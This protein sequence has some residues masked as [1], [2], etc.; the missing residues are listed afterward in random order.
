MELKK[1]LKAGPIVGI[2]DISPDIVI[3]FGGARRAREEIREKGECERQ[4]PQLRVGGSIGS[5]VLALGKL[6]LNPAIISRISNDRYGDFIEAELH[7]RNIND[8]YISKQSEPMVQFICVL[9]EAGERTIYVYE[10]PGAVNPKLRDEDL[11]LELI[12]RCA[13][14]HANGF[15]NGAIV[16][17]MEK[18]S[19]AGAVVS[20]D[21]NLRV[22]QH[23]LSAERRA[24]IER[25]IAA[26]DVIFGSGEEE[27]FPLNGIRDMR[28]SAMALANGKRIVVARDRTAPV[29]VTDGEAAFERKVVP[30][31]PINTLNSGDT[32]NAGFIAATALGKPLQTAVDWACACAASVITS[33]E[34]CHVPGR[35][36][37]E[38]I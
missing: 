16:D 17:Y 36:E 34:P 35:E 8:S 20:F 23:G 30:V 10:G 27:F 5:T 4:Q 13:W 38:R 3:P 22:E 1:A 26:S 19:A 25:A 31:S 29:F 21:L 6:G 32:F 14:L 33:M 28:E 12:P 7:R 11:P 24:R 2:G 18:C 9:D 37:L 15:A